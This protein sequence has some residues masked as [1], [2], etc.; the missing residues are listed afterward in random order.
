MRQRQKT[1][2]IRKVGADEV[3]PMRHTHWKKK[4]EGKSNG[5]AGDIW[6]IRLGWMPRGSWDEGGFDPV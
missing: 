4:K 6:P 5:P 3:G 1:F 2:G